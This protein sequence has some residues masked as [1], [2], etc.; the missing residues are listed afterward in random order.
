MKGRLY[1]PEEGD[2]ARVAQIEQK[3]NQFNLTT[4][5]YSEAAI[6]GFLARED[7]VVLAFRLADRFGDHGLVSTLIGFRE[8]NSLR[9]N[10]WL[11]RVRRV[12]SPFDR[13]IHNGRPFRFRRGARTRSKR[14]MVGDTCR[15]R[16]TTSLPGFTRAS[17][18]L[19]PAAGGSSAIAWHRSTT[20]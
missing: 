17:A 6:R 10:S 20:S 16:R 2:I 7:A 9:I 15:P 13:A 12:F 19:R 4:R 18:S 11:H 1:R 14:S 5:R 8:G 3:T